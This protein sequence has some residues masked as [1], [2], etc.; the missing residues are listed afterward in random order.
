MGKVKVVNGY[1]F[2]S[3]IQYTQKMGTSQDEGKK[4]PSF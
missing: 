3:L 4:I 1:S 2:G